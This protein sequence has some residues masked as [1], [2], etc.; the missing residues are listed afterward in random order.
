[1]L[2]TKSIQ[3]LSFEAREIACHA[4]EVY[5][6]RLSASNYGYLRI[7]SYR[8][9]IEKIIRKYWPDRRRSG[10]KSIKH[11]STFR[12]YC[13]QAVLYFDDMDIPEEDIDAPET[14]GNLNNWERVV[15]FYTLRLML[16]PFVE[17]VILY[18]RM[19]CLQENGES[20]QYAL[21][22]SF[23]LCWC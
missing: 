5:T 11:L 18:D 16:A 7:H 20:L 13:K 15:I 3:Y 2:R 17:S 8:A 10:L 1:M 9:A 6:N 4:I 23:G 12:E 22:I 14:V 21:K 19:L